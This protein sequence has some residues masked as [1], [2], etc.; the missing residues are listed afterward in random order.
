M[1]GLKETFEALNRA[2]EMVT[3]GIEEFANAIASAFSKNYSDKNCPDEEIPKT[4]YK[5]VYKCN[6]G[7]SQTFVQLKKHLPYQ[8]RNY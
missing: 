3:V 7:K 6:L 4:K 2:W 8:R 1:D 5:R